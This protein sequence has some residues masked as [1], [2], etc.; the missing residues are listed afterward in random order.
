[1]SALRQRGAF[2]RLALFTIAFSSSHFPFLSSGI[3]AGGTSLLMGIS[4]AVTCVSETIVFYFAERIKSTLG[5]WGCLNLIFLAFILRLAAYSALPRVPTLWLVLPV[6]LLHGFTFG[7]AWSVG[8]G[9]FAAIAPK[10]TEATFQSFFQGA[11]FGAR[12][13]AAS[14]AGGLL[15][16]RSNR[17][18]C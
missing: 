13:G 12:V 17:R 16:C 10:G 14:D 15:S 1:M 11:Y 4:L 7:L 2:V 9:Y 8:T 18:N 3:F 6:E 5:T